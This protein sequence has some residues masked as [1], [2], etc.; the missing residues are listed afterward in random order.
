[1]PGRLS[2]RRFLGEAAAFGAA[3]AWA[4][5]FRLSVAQ[6]QGSAPPQFPGGIPLYR[7]AFE[8]WARDIHVEDLWTC[9]PREPADVVTLANWAAAHGWTLRAR[10]MMHNWSLLA[11]L[12]DRGFGLTSIPAPGDVTIGGVTAIG[13]HG[14]AMPGD[15]EERAPGRGFGTLSNLVVS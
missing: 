3:A 5:A 1:M 9:A 12:E 7:Q 6:A 8:N 2:R 13:G 11:F 4:P 15:G 10:G 14:A